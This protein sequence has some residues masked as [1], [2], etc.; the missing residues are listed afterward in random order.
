[1]IYVYVRGASH[2]EW[3]GAGDWQSAQQW[4]WSFVSTAQGREE[5]LW[6]FEPGRPF[7]GGGFPELIWQELSWPLL[8]LGLAGIGGFDRRLRFLLYTTLLF[9][10][11][12]C[13]A[14]RFGNW[15][16]V[17]LPAYPLILLGVVPP[18]QRIQRW[19]AQQEAPWARSVLTLAPLLLL[20]VALIWRVD[21]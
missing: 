8:L 4:F 21:Q 5:L 6:A 18:S 17:V 10:L 12:F 9:Y 3:W 1:Y 2:P 14:Y 11:A 15:F 19:A 7:L 13:W 20:G 16:Q